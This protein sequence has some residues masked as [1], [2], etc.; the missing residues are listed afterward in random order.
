M[1]SSC[2]TTLFAPSLPMK[3]VPYIPKACKLKP[4]PKPISKAKSMAI[5]KTAEHS[6]SG[7]DSKDGG[8]WPHIDDD[9]TMPGSNA[10][11]PTLHEAS[12]ASH[13]AGYGNTYS[14]IVTSQQNLTGT[15][16][17]DAFARFH[18][19]SGLESPEH[20][21]FGGESLDEGGADHPTRVTEGDLAMIGLLGGISQE[22]PLI[23]E[24]NA[25]DHS[26]TGVKPS[27]VASDCHEGGYRASTGNE[28]Y[29][30]VQHGDLDTEEVCAL[31][32]EE[33]EN[34]WPNSPLA[35]EEPL[36]SDVDVTDRPSAT[37]KRTH[38]A[39][40]DA[41]P[42]PE[43]ED[44]RSTKRRRPADRL[45]EN[46]VC[47]PA[48]TP[49]PTPLPTPSDSASHSRASTEPSLRYLNSDRKR[50]AARNPRSS[51]SDLCTE[52]DGG[53]SAHNCRTSEGLLHS[54]R[55][56]ISSLESIEGEEYIGPDS[57]RREEY[58]EGGGGDA[59]ESHK[60][61]DI[62]QG[63]SEKTPQRRI[64]GGYLPQKKRYGPSR[65][66][67]RRQGSR[68]MRTRASRQVAS[69]QLQQLYR[70]P[71]D[72]RPRSCSPQTSSPGTKARDWSNID[73]GSGLDMSCQITDLTLCAVPNGSSIIIE[74]IRSRDS[75]R[76]PNPA[77]LGH[78]FLGGEGKVIRMTQLSP[79]SWMLVGYRYEGGASSLCSCGSLN[80]DW[81][82]ISHSDAA[83]DGKDYS[84][85]GE[86][87]W[88]ENSEKEEGTEA[89][90]KRKRRPWLESDEVR[91]LS[92]KDKQG[93]EWKEICERFPNRT[94]GA[95][96]VRYYGLQKKQ[97]R[98]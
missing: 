98:K 78:R 51:P 30:A 32:I 71:I 86:D 80:V 89:Y 49:K 81:M 21:Q 62:S 16:L 52:D 10:S 93:M 31:S 97:K 9:F 83:N 17:V 82:S 29:V 55:G 19:A 85:D 54:T 70:P 94:E 7:V 40:L 36:F 60:D 37:R 57:E 24:G 26:A 53:D 43:L 28:E 90:G 33:I 79:D 69:P 72:N 14:M 5:T 63:P 95:V 42:E 59:L 73:F 66:A 22:L 75:E 76:F 67:L 8:E 47:N 46:L 6:R 41:I 61:D 3:I 65:T 27:N 91:L 77:A 45:A 12:E 34:I 25:A 68:T 39:A 1:T 11:L 18:G 4:K 88:D 58:R 50:D 15:G 74:I 38:P 35:Q 84:D 96:K 44:P 92:L 87:D 13:S 2:S 56:S 23:V 20:D 64:R 48:P